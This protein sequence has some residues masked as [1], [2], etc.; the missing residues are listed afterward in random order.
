MNQD[1]SCEECGQVKNHQNHWAPFGWHNFVPKPPSAP[2]GASE[3]KPPE[4]TQEEFKVIYACVWERMKDLVDWRPELFARVTAEE[5][6]VF[7]WNR[8]SLTPSPAPSTDRAGDGIQRIAAERARQ[9]AVEGWTPK[10]DDEHDDGEMAMAAACY[11]A[12]VPIHAKMLVHSGC[13]CRSV[14]ECFHSDKTKWMDPWPWAEKWDKRKKHSRVRQ[15]E[16]A[17]ALIAAEID[18]LT[19][20]APPADKSAAAQCG[21]RIGTLTELLCTEPKGHSGIHKHIFSDAEL[22]ASAEDSK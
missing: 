12:P 4:I 20:A 18:R 2:A 11:A 6:L 10:H 21:E 3:G 8:R 16:I 15:L 7:L 5:T 1:E 17:G 22:S 14:G 19:R 9:V 13:G